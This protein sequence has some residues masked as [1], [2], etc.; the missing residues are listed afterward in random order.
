MHHDLDMVLHRLLEHFEPYE[1]RVFY[2]EGILQDFSVAH[3]VARIA[4]RK[5]DRKTLL[6]FAAGRRC[7]AVARLMASLNTQGLLRSFTSLN[8]VLFEPPSVQWI[9]KIAMPPCVK[10]DIIYPEHVRDA[11]G[12]AAH[13]QVITAPIRGAEA[14]SWAADLLSRVI[15]KTQASGPSS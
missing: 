12:S 4:A 11:S 1:M 2:S 9:H 15:V 10:I 6:L 8:I 5:L 13:A 7:N 14:P 3:T